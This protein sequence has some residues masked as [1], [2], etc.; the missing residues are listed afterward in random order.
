MYTSWLESK[1]IDL[2]LFIT[3]FFPA[4][5]PYKY[6]HVLS[7]I[8]ICSSETPTYRKGSLPPV[9]PSI[10]SAAASVPFPFSL[11]LFLISNIHIYISS[12]SILHH[13]SFPSNPSIYLI[14]QSTREQHMHSPHRVSSK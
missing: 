6:I 7:T 13:S 1:S 8:S 9:H 5:A 11:F 10:I 2:S 4:N 12:S 3:L 14:Y